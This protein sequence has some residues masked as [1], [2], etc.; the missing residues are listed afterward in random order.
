MSIE[1]QITLYFSQNK[2]R[3]SRK[4]ILVASYLKNYKKEV[5]A[6]TVWMNIK[7]KQLDISIA[8][9]Y[10]ALNWLVELGFATRILKGRKSLYQIKKNAPLPH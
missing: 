9:V 1:E 7:E 4:K 6:E 2:L 3:T 5:P 10:Q 8:S